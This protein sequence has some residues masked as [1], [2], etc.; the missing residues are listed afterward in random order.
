MEI[1]IDILKKT[2]S[3]AHDFGCLKT[4]NHHCITSK[5]ERCV[6]NKVH[7]INCDDKYCNYKM[8]FG[9]STVCNCPI[10]QEIYRKYNM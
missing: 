8:S 9:H 10:R 7:F 3:C 1:D 6:N 2:I 4:E 5:V